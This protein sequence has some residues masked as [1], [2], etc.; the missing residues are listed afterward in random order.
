MIPYTITLGF[1]HYTTQEVLEKVLPEGIDVPSSFE[2]VG[3]VAHVNL[4]DEHEPFKS[5]IG[6][7][8]L[9]KNVHIRTVVNK[10]GSIDN[11]FRFFN[12]EV[13]AGENLT[14]VKVYEEGCQFEFDY[15]KV[16]WNSRLQFEHRRLV[17][18]MNP[19]SYI[20]NHQS[21]FSNKV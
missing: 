6:H 5:L 17:Q 14:K 11:T 2:T 10:V 13:I 12:M 1:E 20:C 16:Y 3:H 9:E 18:L 8:I 4:R 15:A 19:G 7:V 21:S